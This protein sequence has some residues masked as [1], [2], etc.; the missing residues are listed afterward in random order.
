MST[1]F[2]PKD[3]GSEQLS[4][5]LKNPKEELEEA[6]KFLI[7]QNLMFEIS[8]NGLDTINC[9]SQSINKRFD[10][11]MIMDYMRGMLFYKQKNY[12][13]AIQCL[14]FVSGKV[15]LYCYFSFLVL[16]NEKDAKYF[17]IKGYNLIV[18]R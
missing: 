16:K 14:N 2:N 5:F 8:Y 3:I 17:F 6:F 13:L 4:I 18:H 7:L 11:I 9:P 1:H 12:F 15:F 10:V